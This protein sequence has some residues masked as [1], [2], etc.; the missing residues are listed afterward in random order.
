M[1]KRLP[2]AARKD[3]VLERAV[4]TFAARGFSGARTADLAKACGVSDAMLFKL[5]GSKQGLYRAMIEWKLARS[6]EG[7]FPTAAAE[8]GDDRAVFETIAREL[9]RN[10]LKDPA[11]MRLLLFSA[12]EGHPLA[13]MF[14]DVRSRK[15]VAFLAG[16][17]RRRIRE[18]SFRKVDPE[19]TAIAFLGAVFQYV[20]TVQVFRAQGLARTPEAVARNAAGLVLGG[21]RA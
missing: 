12:L 2:A 4:R 6:G 18:G 11:F 14:Y 5:F 7:V 8:A 16:Y 10:T 3:L 17:I 9:L 20:L 13:R 19:L 21:L 1:R 15:V